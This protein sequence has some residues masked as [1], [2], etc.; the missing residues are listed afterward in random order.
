MECAKLRI[1]NTLYLTDRV[2]WRD[3]LEEHHETETEVWLVFYKKHTGKPRIDYTEAVEEAL[4]YGWIDSIVQKIDDEK[5]VQ[6]FS[7]RRDNSKWSE[8]NKRRVKK[9]VEE[10]RMTPAGLSKVDFSVTDTEEQR[11]PK[12]SEAFLPDDM[13]KALKE[14]AVAWENFNKLP[15]S[16]RR[17]YT[18]WILSARREGTRQKRLREALE[19]IQCKKGQQP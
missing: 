12:K 17:N 19:M 1:N 8:L 5:Y 4:C 13:Q 16:H 9:L 14:N 7:P 10:G 3:W 2:A 18:D 15:P 11:E 6:K